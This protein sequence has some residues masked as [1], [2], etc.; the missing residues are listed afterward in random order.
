VP[1][2]N[3]L[4]TVKLK[5]Y[6]VRLFVN[7]KGVLMEAAKGDCSKKLPEKIGLNSPGK[8]ILIVVKIV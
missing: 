6:S 3:N 7:F 2:K 5:E 1:I 8:M 4:F